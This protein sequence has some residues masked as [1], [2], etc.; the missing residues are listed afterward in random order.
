M[1]RG[2]VVKGA[3]GPFGVG[4]GFLS[5]CFLFLPFLSSALGMAFWV[6]LAFL[7]FFCCW[8]LDYNYKMAHACLVSV[9]V[10]DETWTLWPLL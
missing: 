6:W 7:P 8:L 9:I 1:Q 4:L 10:F 3:L 5:G 2:G